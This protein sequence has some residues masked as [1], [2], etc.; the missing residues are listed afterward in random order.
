MDDDDDDD[1]PKKLLIPSFWLRTTRKGAS[2][3]SFP[4]AMQ[5]ISQSA[6]AGRRGGGGQ[7]VFK[8]SH[9]SGRLSG[10]GGRAMD[11]AFRANSSSRLPITLC[12]P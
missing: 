1:D 9:I 12:G 5:R 2:G 8:R 6:Q 11:G 4:S 10:K 7:E 3:R